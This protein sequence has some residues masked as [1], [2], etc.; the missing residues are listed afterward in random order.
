MYLVI[1]GCEKE[2][3][4]NEKPVVSTFEVTRITGHE[5]YCGGQITD[6]GNVDVIDR[7]VVWSTVKNPT[8]EVNEGVENQVIGAWVFFVTMTNLAEGTT[9]YLRAYATNSEGTSYGDEKI[10]STID[11]YVPILTTTPAADVAYTAVQSGGNITDNGKLEI[12]ARGIVWDTIQNPTIEKNN[13]KTTNENGTG[14]FTSNVWDLADGTTYYLR[15]YATNSE[16]TGYGE[17]ISFKTK[18]FGKIADI[19]GNIYKTVIIG[20]QE[21]MAENLRVKMFPIG[22]PIPYSE[23]HKIWGNR[24]DSDIDLGYCYYNHDKSKAGTNGALYT[25]ETAM[26]GDTVDTEN[27]TYIQGICPQGWHIPSKAEW[28]QLKTYLTGKGYNVVK[29]LSNKTGWKSY[30]EDVEDNNNRTGFSAM[31][32]GFLSFGDFV[33]EYYSTLWWTTNKTSWISDSSCLRLNYHYGFEYYG[34]PK[35]SGN[36]VRCLKD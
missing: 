16:G 30:G 28:W 31:P 26:A 29:S 23:N 10:F 14:E 21:W 27:S 6:P 19:E 17:E 9:Y 32:V 33:H 8:V 13:G 20:E 11:L 35:S 12:T 1:Y 15:A 4:S 2:V 7:G 5:A 3:E 18:T 34:Y 24:L 22:L 25:W 36:S